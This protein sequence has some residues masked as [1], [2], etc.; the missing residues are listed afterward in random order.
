MSEHRPDIGLVD[1]VIVRESDIIGRMPTGIIQE[2][3]KNVPKET[4]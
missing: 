4:Y 1:G 3:S 2:Q